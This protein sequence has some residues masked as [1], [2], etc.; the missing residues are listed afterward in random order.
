MT[1]LALGFPK[2]VD[3]SQRLSVA[4]LFINKKPRCGIYLLSF[5]DG[6]FYIGQSSNVVRRFAEH[7]SNYMDI[8]G[9]AFLD[10]IQKDLHQIEQSLIWKAEGLGMPLRNIVHMSTPS[11]ETDL[12]DILTLEQQDQSVEEPKSFDVSDVKVGASQDP[13]FRE[14]YRRRYEKL[15]ADAFFPD[16][17]QLLRLYICQCIPAFRH[18]EFTFWAISCLPSTNAETYPRFFCIS[19][20]SMEVF[21]I[22]RERGLQG[23]LWGFMNLSKKSFSEI[24]ENSA[25][26]HLKH[27]RVEI[28]ASDYRAGGQDQMQLRFSSLD[29]A[30]QLIQDQVVARAS[31]VL[32]LHLMRKGATLYSRYHSFDLADSILSQQQEE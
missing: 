11:G 29:D 9:F 5:S 15:S 13:T 32:N 16:L 18:T 23:N 1:Y 26:F 12:D 27:P 19:A 28:E 31:R 8:F 30:R 21:V 10:I 20:N 17:K 7:K 3:V 6:S 22:G 2:L 14:R 4:D 25:R 24:Y